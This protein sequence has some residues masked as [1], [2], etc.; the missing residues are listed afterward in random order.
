LCV[1]EKLLSTKEETLNVSQNSVL[2]RVGTV[3]CKPKAEKE[4]GD[5][6]RLHNEGLPNLHSS[7][8]IIRMTNSSRINWARNVVSMR[9]QINEYSIL[10]GKPAGKRPPGEPGRNWKSIKRVPM[11]IG[12]DSVD[13]IHLMS[14]DSWVVSRIKG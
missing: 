3:I 1:G 11:A 8:N 5:R 9:E 6:G 2:K 7:P 10:V 14:F 13:W 4:T 12:W